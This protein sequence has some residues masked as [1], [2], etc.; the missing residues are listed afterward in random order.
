MSSGPYYFREKEI[1]IHIERVC[2]KNLNDDTKTFCSDCPFRNE[3]IRY[4]PELGILFNKKR[5]QTNDRK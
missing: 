4:F 5:E 2:Y 1:K 3:I